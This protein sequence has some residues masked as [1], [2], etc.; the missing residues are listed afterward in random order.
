MMYVY[1]LFEKAT[2]HCIYIGKTKNSK[3]RMCKHFYEN[4]KDR[5][6]ELE[7]RIMKEYEEKSGGDHWE[8]LYIMWYDAKRQLDNKLGK[9]ILQYEKLPRWYDVMQK[10]YDRSVFE[11]KRKD[12]KYWMD[13]AGYDYMLERS[14]TSRSIWTIQHKISNINEVYIGECWNSRDMEGLKKKLRMKYEM[15]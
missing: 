15:K 6:D 9:K 14:K 11:R 4:Y 10:E 1:G 12:L 8:A 2:G 5:K 3:K 7:F 13:L